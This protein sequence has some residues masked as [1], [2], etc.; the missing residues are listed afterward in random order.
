MEDSVQKYLTGFRSVVETGLSTLVTSADPAPLYD[1]AR[2]ALEGKGKR[3]RAS[4]LLMSAEMFGC[5]AERALPRALAME[6]FHNFTLVHDDIMDA[7]DLRRGRPTLHRRWDE[8]TAI[9]C[10]DLLMGLSYELLATGPP[11]RLV[12]ML[13]VHGRTVRLLCEG[14]VLDMMFESR[15]TVSV[16]EYMRMISLKTAAL[17][18][19]SLVLGGLSGSAGENDLERLSDIGYNLGIAFQI[20]DDL[21]D[22]TTSDDRWGKP[23]GGDLI[24]GKKTFLLLKALELSTGGEYDWFSRIL[25]DGGLDAKDVSV[26]K[27]RMSGLG[28]LEEAQSSVI[29][30]SDRAMELT[31]SLPEGMPRDGLRFVIDKMQRRQH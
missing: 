1:S 2:F 9:L 13:H 4:L 18:Q 22:L 5:E 7:S 17:L 15:H 25:D 30:H 21:L 20:Q 27:D 8:P 23:V 16:A 3:I 24:A 12:E 6:V 11:E 19:S 10:G 14:Q 31:E 26:A 28:V 29:F